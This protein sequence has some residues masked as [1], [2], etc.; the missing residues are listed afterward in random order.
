M[1]RIVIHYAGIADMSR[2]GIVSS[3][4]VD[5]FFLPCIV[6]DSMTRGRIHPAYL[7]ALVLIVF[8]QIAQT[9]VVHWLPWIN[10]SLMLQRLVA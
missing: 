1:F 6:Y 5:A 4:L 10:L 3:L 2:A 9:R 8:D 7:I